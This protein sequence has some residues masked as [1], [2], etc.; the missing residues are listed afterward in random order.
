LSPVIGKRAFGLVAGTLL[1]CIGCVSLMEKTGKALDGSAFAEKKIARY[2][3]RAK[4]GAEFDMEILHAQDKAGQRLLVVSQGKFPAVQMRVTEPDSEQNFYVSSVDYVSGNTAGWNQYSMELSG[5]G[6]CVLSETGAVFSLNG[7]IEKVQITQGK[8]R[9]YDT[10][11]IGGNAVNNLRNREDRIEALAEWMRGREDAPQGLDRKAFQNFWKP[12]LF[13]EI[14]PKR[15]RPA[16]WQLDGDVYKRAEEIKWNTGYSQR[17][18]P[19]LFWPVRDSGTLLRDWEEAF[20]WIYLQYE[21]E[22]FIGMFSREITL[23]KVK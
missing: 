10:T 3:A 15:K 6:S 4:E 7:D 13:P 19:E 9:L 11:I 14:C 20:E 23:K 16:G 1:L 21:W 5:T 2:R 22:T 12:V 8:I 17:V 18:F